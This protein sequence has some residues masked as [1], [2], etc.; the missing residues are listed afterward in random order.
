MEAETSLSFK[1]AK[2]SY[3]GFQIIGNAPANHRF[4]QNEYKLMP[5]KEF[6]K[7]VRKE[8]QILYNCLPRE[9]TVKTFEDRLDLF[10]AMIE[11]PS[12]TPYEGGVFL[13][14]FQLPESYPQSPPKVHYYS[15]VGSYEFGKVNANLWN[16]GKVC[17]SILGTFPGPRW[18]PKNS[19]ILQVLLSIQ[20]LVLVKEPYYNAPGMEL[21]G[22]WNRSSSR[23]NCFVVKQVLRMT[24]NLVE[25]PPDLFEREILKHLQNDTLKMLE[26]IQVW[27]KNQDSKCTW[28]Q[29][30]RSYFFKEEQQI[31]NFPIL[32]HWKLEVAE[33]SSLANK[34]RLK[35]ENLFES[36]SFQEE[37][38]NKIKSRNNYEVKEDETFSGYDYEPPTGISKFKTFVNQMF[39]NAIQ[40]VFASPW[41]FLAYIFADIIFSCIRKILN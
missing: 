1:D 26:K 14:D 6:Y 30:L 7:A 15:Y 39:S 25:N 4:K 27:T 18:D 17:L 16:N 29:F 23:H 24:Q 5:G 8:Y 20:G 22:S 21:L 2:D 37:E 12:D 40:V 13:F 19:T 34:T 38:T 3:A 32:S 33:I 10:S 31:F 41:L 35:I 36:K 11:G 9:I 28:H